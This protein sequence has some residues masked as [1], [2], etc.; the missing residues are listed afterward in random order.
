MLRLLAFA[1]LPATLAGQQAQ[2]PHPASD[3]AALAPA[4]VEQRPIADSGNAPPSYPQLLQQA[5]VG[6]PVRVLFTVDT[7]GLPE[8]A[9]IR[10]ARSPNPGFDFIVK[11]AVT[12]WRFAPA[13]HCARRVRVRLAHEFLFQPMPPDTSRLV[14]VFEFDTTV[15]LARDTLPDGTPRTTLGWRRSPPVVA[16]LPW[17]SLAADSAEEAVVASLVDNL[18]AWKDSLPRIVCLAGRT[19]NADPDAG[20]LVR[21]NQK[22]GVTV[23]PSRRCPPTFSS[24]MYVPGQRPPPPGDD[25][26]HIRVKTR[27]AISVAR[28]LFDVDVAHGTGGAQYQCGAERR[29]TGWRA[30]CIVVS[31]WSS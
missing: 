4:D 30:Q 18:S 23:L 14:R 12:R 11:R 26:Y 6:G 28:F 31:S 24:M 1:F 27:K 19:Q 9:S 13:S 25:P 5:R 3:T 7:A 15:T 22:G 17:D 10:V 20:W 2:C 29:T 21:L 16:D 8:P